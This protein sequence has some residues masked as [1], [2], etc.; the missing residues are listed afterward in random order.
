MSSHHA[1]Q[2]VWHENILLT[3]HFLY[4]ARHKWSPLLYLP[5]ALGC[6]ELP[7]AVQQE[8]CMLVSICLFCM[9]LHSGPALPAWI[10]MRLL[11]IRAYYSALVL[12]C[13]VAGL[14]PELCLYEAQVLCTAF[15]TTSASQEVLPS[16]PVSHILMVHPPTGLGCTPISLCPLEPQFWLRPSKWFTYTLRFRFCSDLHCILYQH[17][18]YCL[19]WNYTCSM[20]VWKENWAH[21][22]KL[23]HSNWR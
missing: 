18:F 14:S 8:V 17:K 11:Y 19:H 7:Y 1:M 23:H 9:R 13:L 2:W 16:Y 15:L 6:P 20:P 10:S 22:N 5:R 12:M 3:L 4:T 21:R